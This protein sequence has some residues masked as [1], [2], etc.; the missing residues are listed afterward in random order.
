MAAKM[1]CRSAEPDRRALLF[2]T[3]AAALVV[4]APAFA[5]PRKVPIIVH[6]DPACGCCGAWVNYLKTSQAFAVEVRIVSDLGPVKARLGV[7]SALAS[8]HTAEVAGYVIEGHVPVPDILQLLKNHPKDVA[9]LAVPG[10]VPGSPG[11]EV[12]GI[13]QPYTVVAFDR[14]G[15]SRPFTRYPQAKSA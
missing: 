10:M 3:A 8:C 1:K 14:A 2:G 4:A 12:P 5:A 11:M 7:P 9:G 15:R 13:S 6:R